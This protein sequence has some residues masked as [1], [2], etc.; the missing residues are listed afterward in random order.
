[1]NF[2]IQPRLENE[3][4]ML[5]P[6][7]NEDFEAL[8][9][10]ASDP[11]IWEQHPNRDRWKKEVFRNFFDGAMQSAGAF[12]IVDK[13]TGSVIGSTRF[14]DYNE[15]EN[16]ILIGYTFYGLAYWGKG[17]N[18]SV[19]AMMLDYAFRFVSKVHFHIGAGN[20]RSQI[21]IGRIGASRI[22]EQEVAYFGEA[23]KLNFV[24]E[25]DSATWERKKS[26]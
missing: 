25:I 24:Y 15:Q 6:L 8:Y 21:A 23:P 11:K 4:V 5:C 9:S 3:K 22:A 12:K 16:T 18:Y 20:I 13:A 19:K 2:S 14:Y 7:C 17:I 1:M 10:V 26:L